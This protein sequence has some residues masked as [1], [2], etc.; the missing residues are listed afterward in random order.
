LLIKW[1]NDGSTGLK[2]FGSSRDASVTFDQ[3][4][5]QQRGLEMRY[6]F[7]QAQPIEGVDWDDLASLI[8]NE[9]FQVNL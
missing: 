1:Q 5:G 3:G 2:H 6:R 9:F 4:F 8:D 7:S